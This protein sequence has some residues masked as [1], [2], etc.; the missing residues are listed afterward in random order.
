[1]D[2]ETIVIT[3]NPDILV[4]TETW[5]HCDISDS[6]IT[7]VGYRIYRKDRGSRGGGVAVMFRESVTATRLPDI[8][9][10]EYVIVKFVSGDFHLL[11]GAF[12]RPPSSPSSF[13]EKLNEFLCV[14]RSSKSNLLLV[15]DFNVPDVSWADEFPDA[16]SASAEPLVD[17]VLLHALTQLVKLPTRVNG[18]SASVLYLFLVNDTLLKRN[19]TVHLFEGIS[20]HKMACLTIPV[21]V[22][23]EKQKREANS[24]VCT[25]KRCRHT[26]YIR[27]FTF[28]FCVAV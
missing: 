3:H 28:Y 26:R 22:V 4:I 24:H 27:W 13:F 10:V 5:L 11:V 14:H 12:Y 21:N 17:I 9:D 19:P 20:D 25:S 6:E 7:P 18:N 8:A 23:P 16:L 1:M 15:G 2:L